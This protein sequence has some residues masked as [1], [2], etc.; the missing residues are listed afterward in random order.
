M[1]R[2]WIRQLETHPEGPPSKTRLPRDGEDHARDR[3]PLGAPPWRRLALWLGV[4]LFVS[5]VVFGWWR[6]STG[7]RESR[8]ELA[9]LLAR[10]QQLADA[11]RDL[12]RQV[13]ALRGEREA[14]ARAAR[15]SLDVAAPDET[16][17]IVP[18]TPPAR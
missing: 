17:V 1:R 7:V 13:K 12:A 4:V 9:S 3:R 10:Q 18:P 6:G 16:V 5:L 15:E 2:G 8:R 14:R 11:N